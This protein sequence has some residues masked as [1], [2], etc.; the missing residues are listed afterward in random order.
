MTN[1]REI[2]DYIKLV[3]SGKYACCREQFQLCDLI[4]K[5]FRTERLTVNQN[6]LDKYLSYQKYFPFQLFDWEKF[7]FALHNCVYRENGT[8]RFPILFMYVGRG[9]GKNGYLA[10]EDF[11][12]LT[13]VNGVPE[14]DID[15]FATAEDQAK[16]S[17][18]DVYTV[19][20]KNKPKMKK[21]FRW[22]KEIIVNLDTNSTFRFRTSNFKTKDG[23]RPG[24]VDFDEYHAYEN[25]KLIEVAVTGLGKR[26][27][28]RRT[29]ITTDGNVR[30][31]VLD[32]QLEKCEQ[33][34][35]GEVA[36]NGTIPFLCRLDCDEEVHDKKNWT[37][38]NPSY[39][40]LPHLQ[41]EM[42]LEYA[43]YKSNPIANSSFMKKRMNRPPS[44]NEGDI[45][46]WAN[47]QACN[48]P[49]DETAIFGKPCVIGIDYA[50][51]NDFLGAGL[52]WRADGIDY[53]LSHTWICS[54]APDLKG[55]N[56]PLRE[57]EAMGICTFVNSAELSTELPCA[58]LE[59]EAR[60]RNA[61]IMRAG[62]DF[63]RYQWLKKA[64]LDINFS[65]D[66]QYG[67][68]MLVR[69]S[70]EMLTIPT[71][72][73]KFTNHQIAW[74]DSPMMKWCC[75][76]AKIEI[77]RHG[78]MTYEKI[79]KHYRKIDTFK[80]FVSAE[81]ASDVLDVYENKTDFIPDMKVYVY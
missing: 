4:E 60:K 24:K 77:G 28:A 33:I 59:N 55:I 72:T 37:K 13:D 15:I 2:D 48:R 20:E 12:L 47:I 50:Q 45:T 22:N 64:L 8:L 18:Q 34:L 25:Y 63:Y 78:N 41:R 10:F 67:N 19:L 79:E 23:G 70:N 36:D 17:W 74:G 3:R 14:Y 1:C 52:L 26:P 6:Q 35:S 7:C 62:I 61:K 51:T 56:P 65:A 81:C 71:I 66:K 39:P 80:A 16:M 42:E 58:W 76:N 21:H 54:S 30:D 73:S 32:N 68:V 53:W 57:W 29:I 46:S 44:Q 38:P 49:I 75:R 11:C 40:F 5:I 31:G 43:E 69:P 9:A 27:H